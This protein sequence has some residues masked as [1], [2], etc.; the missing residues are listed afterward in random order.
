M[1]DFVE[2]M[3]SIATSDQSFEAK[4]VAIVT[5]HVNKYC[6]KSEALRVYHAERLALLDKE[7]LNLQ[8]FGDSYRDHLMDIFAEGIES[9]SVRKSIDCKFAAQAVIGM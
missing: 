7:R 1:R 8:R 2:R 3:H 5:F 4:L 6:E 9:G